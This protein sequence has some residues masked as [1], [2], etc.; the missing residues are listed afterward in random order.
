M[1]EQQFSSL[2]K[3]EQ[4]QEGSSRDWDST[5]FTASPASTAEISITGIED[6]S[7]KTE[8][9][10]ELDAHNIGTEIE[11]T[12]RIDKNGGFKD[13][14]NELQRD[15]MDMD[16]ERKISGEMYVFVEGG[17]QT[18]IHIYGL[19]RVFDAIKE[20]RKVSHSQSNKDHFV[21]DST[22]FGIIKQL[23]PD[24]IKREELFWKIMDDASSTNVR[25]YN[26]V[27]DDAKTYRERV[28]KAMSSMRNLNHPFRILRKLDW[29]LEYRQGVMDLDRVLSNYPEKAKEL[30]KQIIKFYD[31][32]TEL[33]HFREN[34]EYEQKK[35]FNLKREQ[36]LDKL[37][38][39]IES[40]AKEL[41][42][43]FE[44][45]RS[46]ILE[47]LSKFEVVEIQN[48]DMK[49]IFAGLVKETE[50]KISERRQQT[51]QKI[52]EA[53]AE[54]KKFR[55]IEERPIM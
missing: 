36:F 26:S 24:R 13:Q 7:L 21:G 3:I 31:N 53:T 33:L 38:K 22:M 1:S 51:D 40:I 28:R 9:G 41:E 39:E 42:D 30:T 27:F 20:A 37:E 47:N 49:E 45:W 4:K 43:E 48:E 34:K 10:T 16:I 29:F 5:A 50:D 23:E 2:K 19:K 35:Q 11:Q 55:L 8:K 14:Y 15:L 32:F 18:L 6:R 12:G 46:S 54:L 17:G 44:A 52:S 25:C